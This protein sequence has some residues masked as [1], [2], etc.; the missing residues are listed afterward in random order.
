MRSDCTGWID[1]DCL[2]STA[3]LETLTQSTHPV[4]REVNPHIGSLQGT[5]VCRLS[6][7]PEQGPGHHLRKGLRP[8]GELQACRTGGSRA[9]EGLWLPSHNPP[10]TASA[11]HAYVIHIFIIHTSLSSGTWRHMDIKR[12]DRGNGIWCK[13]QVLMR[14][15]IYISHAAPEIWVRVLVL[16]FSYILHN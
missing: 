6:V 14:D 2:Q 1:R 9:E 12:C 13:Y 4:C 5:A 8:P 15:G 7:V 11:A 10:F 3:R 16:H